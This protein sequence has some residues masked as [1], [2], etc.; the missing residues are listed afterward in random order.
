METE[1]LGTFCAFNILINQSDKQIKATNRCYVGY[2]KRGSFSMVHGNLIALYTSEF[3][4]FKSID[5]VSIN[6]AVSS[7]KG[8]YKYYLQKPNSKFFKNRL[9][10]ANPLDRDIRVSVSGNTFHLGSRCCKAI[11]VSKDEEL[12]V[13]ESDFIF[14]RPLVFS[15]NKDFV[16]VHH[17]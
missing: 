5:T 3:L 12:T 14:P 6:P 17:G 1:S 9:I 4:G 16:D 8:K 11:T 13:I 15:E 2:G 7:R 10:F